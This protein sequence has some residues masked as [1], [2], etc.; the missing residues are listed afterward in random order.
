MRSLLRVEKELWLDRYFVKRR[1]EI[2][3]GRERLGEMRKE[4]EDVRY[5]RDRLGKTRDGKSSVD[6]VRG[7][8]EYLEGAL[9]GDVTSEEGEEEEKRKERQER[10]RGSY[11]AILETMETKIKG[12]FVWIF[13]IF[14]SGLTRRLE[15]LAFRILEYETQLEILETS[16]TSLFSS[17]NWRTLGPYRLTSILF[18]NGLNG[19]GSSWSVT[20]G[21]DGE[22]YRISDLDKERIDLDKV[23]SDKTGLF[24]DAGITFAFYQLQ[25]VEV[26]EKEV[27][28]HLK[29]S[30]TTFDSLRDPPSFSQHETKLTSPRCVCSALLLVTTTLSLRPFP[31]LTPRQSI[32]GTS[33]LSN[34]FPSPV[35]RRIRFLSET[36]SLESAKTKTTMPIRFRTLVCLRLQK[37]NKQD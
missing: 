7:V 30:P 26:E 10:M 32:P 8:V 11:R 23:L 17:P 20:L 34:A 27:P 5:K 29:V 22:W 28:D 9:G 6:V 25:E 4:F 1:K 13:P 35:T 16:M 36:R 37:R 15:S 12:K 3:E 2:K 14:K 31:N 18:R 33:L 21:D 19:R 24:L